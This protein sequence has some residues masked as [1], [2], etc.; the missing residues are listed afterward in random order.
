MNHVGRLLDARVS[1]RTVVKGAGAAGI[2][3]SLGAT[4]LSLGGA[5]VLNRGSSLR[6]VGLLR[7]VAAQDETVEQIINIAITA[8][9][10]AV[11][12]LG[13]AVASAEAGMYD[14]PIPDLVVEILKAARAEEQFHYDYLAAE[15]AVPLTTTFTVPDP[16]LLTSTSTLF[17]TLVALETAFVAAYMAAA[18]RFA[19]LGQV[20][21]VKIAVQTA[22]VEGEHRVLANYV[23]G[24]RPADNYAF[25][26]NLFPSV[27][28]AAQA[29]IDLGF[30]GG[31]GTEVSYPGPG[32]IDA[33]MVENTEPSGL[34]VSCM[35]PMVSS[36]ATVLTAAL[37]GADP[38]G[39]GFVK[40]VIDPGAGSLCFR[41]S[42]ARLSGATAAHIHEGG[43]GIA[44]PVVVPLSPPV[45]DGLVNDCV[46]ADPQLLQAIVDNP[47]NYYVNVHNDEYP[48]GAIRGQLMPL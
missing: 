46:T 11:T 29:L 40:V 28:A 3:L 16:A 37:T 22:A 33:S 6:Q 38:D 36:G 39:F 27:G 23:L 14:E 47:G 43:P 25:Y 7:A 1:R 21:L 13:G 45:M 31:S 32:E 8:E 35:V 20:E 48:D 9:A 2:G 18:Y 26:P 44:G 17:T 5:S 4:N 12:L 19:E 42:V 30:I 15:G 41:M 10:L 34:S 24:T